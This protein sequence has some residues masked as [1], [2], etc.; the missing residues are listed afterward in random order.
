MSRFVAALVYQK[1]AGSMARKSI[2]AYCAERAN[3]DGSGIWA[4]KVRIAKEVECSKQT[5]IDTLKT[6]VD[7]GLMIEAG[8]RKTP[9]GYT[10][11]YAINI[12]AVKALPDAFEDPH[13]VDDL[14]SG[15][16]IG[17]VKPFDGSTHLTPRSQLA[18]P[19]GVNPLDPNRP[20][21]VLKPS[22]EGSDLFSESETGNVLN[23]ALGIYRETAREA[24][25]PDI[26]EFTPERQ[27]QLRARLKDCGGLTGWEREMRRAATCPHL[28]GKNDRGWKA[29][30][31][32]FLRKDRFLKLMEGGY[33]GPT[34]TKPA[35]T[36]PGRGHKA[37][38]PQW[39]EVV[40]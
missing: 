17:P 30:L 37:S 1:R 39:G 20:L 7:E 10:V 16:K 25:W 6:F 35:D 23:E 3:D 26:R 11:E 24:G 19:Q 29:N 13:S 31:D 27:K 2:L 4:S 38:A 22:I 32:F 5:V 18:G 36:G 21:T 8:R 34:F 9:H 12:A 15:S 28:I 40:R 14:G 33:D